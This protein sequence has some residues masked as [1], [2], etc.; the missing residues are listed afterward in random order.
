MSR[1]HRKSTLYYYCD[2]GAFGDISSVEF[3]NR[4]ARTNGSS[5][6]QR[7]GQRGS[8]LTKIGRL[9]RDMIQSCRKGVLKGLMWFKR[10][11]WRPIRVVTS[12][13]ILPKTRFN[14]STRFRFGYWLGAGN[15]MVA[16]RWTRWRSKGILNNPSGGRFSAA[17][18]S[19]LH[20]ACPPV[21]RPGLWWIAARDAA[22]LPG[23]S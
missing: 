4:I 2:V 21:F 7:H 5:R 16:S 10:A 20:W 11:K 9:C 22:K 8:E 19:L 17:A 18:L 3:A 6:L 13:R 1:Q 14:R 23:G 12:K 15:R